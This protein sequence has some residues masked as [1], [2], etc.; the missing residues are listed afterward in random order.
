MREWLKQKRTQNGLTMAEMAEKLD[1]T[2]SYYSR[3]E[4]G[5]RQKNMDISILRKLSSIFDMTAEEIINLEE[6]KA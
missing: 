1:L 3:I 4:S 6:P 2:E 5:D